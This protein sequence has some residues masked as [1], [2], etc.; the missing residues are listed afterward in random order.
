MTAVT[1]VLNKSPLST[2]LDEDPV[3]CGCRTECFE[4]N[5]LRTVLS[6]DIFVHPK[7]A[8]GVGVI[9]ARVIRCPTLFSGRSSGTSPAAGELPESAV[10]RPASW[11][12]VP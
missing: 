6:A 11:W 12:R 3:D 10:V 1:N 9:T 7:S 8:R 2:V 5:Q 4:W